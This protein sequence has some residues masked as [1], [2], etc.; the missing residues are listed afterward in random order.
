MNRL[1]MLT[2]VGMLCFFPEAK[3]ADDFSGGVAD[4]LAGLGVEPEGVHSFLGYKD[5]WRRG[6]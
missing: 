4:E 5:A 6:G 3:A 2:I 1:F